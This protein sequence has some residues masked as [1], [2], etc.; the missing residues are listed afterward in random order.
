MVAYD[1]YLSH[2]LQSHFLL[3]GSSSDNQWIIPITL[4]QGSYD[5]S[6]TFLLNSKFA[7][8]NLTD[9]GN[10]ANSQTTWIKLNIDQVGLYKVQYDN[11]LTSRLQNAIQAN[12]LS[13]MDKYGMSI[14]P[15]PTFII[16][17]MSKGFLHL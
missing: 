11:E 10:Q 7:K 15:L 14:A 2:L 5:T 12:Q 13:A 4:S 16:S 8:L 6:K 1:I 17:L 3:D 9:Q